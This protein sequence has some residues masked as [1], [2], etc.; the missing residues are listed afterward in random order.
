[1]FKSEKGQKV[2]DLI[3]IFLITCI[4]LAFI[5][6]L[7][8]DAVI[9]VVD[10]FPLLVRTLYVAFIQFSIAGLGVV[11]I[12]LWRKEKF[13]DY[14]IRKEGITKSMVFG[15]VLLVLFIVY[16]YINEG[17]ISYFPFR[18]VNLTPELLKAGFPVNIVGMLIVAT[19]WGFFEGFNYV[20]LS[21]KINQLVNIKSPF[22]RLGPIIMGISC[23]LVHGAV[24]QNMLETLG[25][26]FLVYMMLIIPELTE[27]SWGCILIFM[28]FWN[29]V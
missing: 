17:N 4:T 9:G 1:M 16:T 25:S 19:A 2:L 10:G 3:I 13:R 21:R 7:G 24:G 11:I 18:Q 22:L 20:Y 12:M 14:G 29:A 6:T 28:M 23:I 8:Q 5:M 27:N 26:F 15:G